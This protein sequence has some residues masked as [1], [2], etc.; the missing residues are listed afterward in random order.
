MDTHKL[1]QFCE[2]KA[3]E[4]GTNYAETSWLKSLYDV[5]S[6]SRLTF[7]DDTVCAIADAMCAYCDKH[8]NGEFGGNFVD[9]EVGDL[10][11]QAAERMLN[12]ALRANKRALLA[13]NPGKRWSYIRDQ[14][15]E[16]AVVTMD[17]EDNYRRWCPFTDQELDYTICVIDTDNIDPLDGDLDGNDWYFLGMCLESDDPEILGAVRRV[18]GRRYETNI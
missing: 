4:L 6:Y 15:I 13:A 2:R 7:S 12:V 11:K 16:T 3:E 1:K 10:S 9:E 18:V 17:T 5:R 14:F 8:G